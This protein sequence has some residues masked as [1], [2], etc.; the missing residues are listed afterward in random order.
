MA[1]GSDE[2]PEGSSHLDIAQFH[3]DEENRGKL[4]ERVLECLDCSNKRPTELHKALL[5]LPIR[6]IFTTNFDD[7]LEKA[8]AQ[9]GIHCKA[10][11]QEIDVPRFGSQGWQVVKIHG[12][13]DHL[14]SIILTAK[15]YENYFKKHRAMRRLIE[16][17]LQTRTVLFLGYSFS[18]LDLRMMLQEVISETREFSPLPYIVL[19]DPLES[20][21]KTLEKRGLKVIALQT[22]GRKKGTVLT[23]W[24]EELARRVRERESS[25]GNIGAGRA[26]IHN[27]PHPSYMKFV[28][29]DDVERRAL[30]GL[31]EDPL[32]VIEGAP[33]IGK[34]SLAN[35]IARHCVAN[36]KSY[37]FQCVVWVDAQKGPEEKRCLNEV[38]NKIASLTQCGAIAQ[39]SVD[40]LDRKKQEVN[41]VL[42]DH[43]TLIIIDNSEEVGDKELF[44]WLTSLPEGSKAM[45][46]TRPNPSRILPRGC[47]IRIDGL[48]E[49][50]ARIFIEQLARER[51]IG[52]YMHRQREQDVLELIRVVNGNPQA[53][54]QSIGLI[55]GGTRNLTEVIEQLQGG[56][57]QDIRSILQIL[58]A[59][60][61]RLLSEDARKI[62]LITPLFRGG[63]RSA[64]TRW[65]PWRA[66]RT[67]LIPRQH[68]TS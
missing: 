33:G 41:G 44:E 29:R 48:S 28:R 19:F 35:F 10:I 7:L 63:I 54:E 27:L 53:L 57:G 36:A 40:D 13:L 37:G 68:Y 56:Q 43:K 42:R 64:E 62:L 39:I 47:L 58:F 34:T 31:K 17:E 49:S 5:S 46:V 59:W 14:D 55:A 8:L 50:E 22:E 18:D 1:E 20:V 52:A 26:V 32:I 16:F 21:K 15:D 2:Y 61:W 30:D 6:H 24:L 45:L 9:E 66:Y 23:Q 11:I 3:E 38:L 51:D 12:D 25:S 4:V 67:R 65:R 60:S